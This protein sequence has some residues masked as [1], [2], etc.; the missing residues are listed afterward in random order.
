MEKELKIKT[1]TGKDIDKVL[2]KDDKDMDARAREAVRAA[3]EKAKFCKKPIAK[4]DV[5][6]KRAYL[7][8][9]SGARRYVK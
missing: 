6:T 3:I 2:T 8:Y 7:E 4:Y 1:V 5:K 9:P